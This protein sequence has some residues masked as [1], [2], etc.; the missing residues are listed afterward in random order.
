VRITNNMRQAQVLR[1]LQ[2]NLTA[3]ARAQAQVASGKRF[4]RSS[5]DPVGA[6]RVMRS[7][8]AL[9]GLTQYRRNTTA[10]R[11]RV[12]AQEAVLSQLTD[13]LT[14]AK[15]LAVTQASDTASAATRADT[16]VEVDALIQQVIQL[17]NT[18]VGDEHIFGGH[19]TSVPPF[20]GD[21]TYVGD[22]G[23]RQSEIATGYLVTAN[24][25]GRELLA[26]SGVISGLVALRDQLR[27]GDGA[28]VG[29]TIA[30]LNDA[31]D[32]VQVLLAQTGARSRQLDTALV[33]VDSSET[34]LK[35]ALDAD[36][37]ISIE[38]ATTRMM[39][40]QTTLQA[41]LMST[42]SLLQTSLTEYL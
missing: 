36:Q 3:L 18:R 29:G 15:E 6:S 19:Q 37:G 25:S 35:V 42:A 13:L 9:R 33:N 30:G 23:V 10:V 38:E 17:G 41:A 16:A 32:S 5:E 20:Q 34:S 24:H 11:A 4:T 39:A 40:V 8:Q 26:D 21:G 7:E 31:F 22:D 27:A 28:A 14:R 1:N 12:D 2:S